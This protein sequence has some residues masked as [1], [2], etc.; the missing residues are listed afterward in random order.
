MRPR[1]LLTIKLFC[2]GT[3]RHNSILMSLLLVVAETKNGQLNYIKYSQN[4]VVRNIGD[5]FWFKGDQIAADKGSNLERNSKKY[6]HQSCNLWKRQPLFQTTLL[7]L[8]LTIWDGQI[9]TS[10][11]DKKDS[12][13]DTLLCQNIKNSHLKNS[14]LR[15][16]WLIYQ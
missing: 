3:D 8:H 15:R 4:G 5:T 14:H 13:K 16:I 9:H 6:F 12:S 11:Y 2:T 7:H 10:L 1:L